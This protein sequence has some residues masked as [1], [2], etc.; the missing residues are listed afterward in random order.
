MA[1]REVVVNVNIA[2]LPNIKE[3]FDEAAGAIEALRVRLA[4][5]VDALADELALE[6]SR[7]P[8]VKRKVRAAVDLLY[9]ETGDYRDAWWLR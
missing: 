6:V 2:D 1:R 7:T 5:L 8:E 4:E 9:D 3:R